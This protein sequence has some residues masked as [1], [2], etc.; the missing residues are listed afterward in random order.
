MNDARQLT[1]WCNSRKNKLLFRAGPFSVYQCTACDQVFV[2]GID[3]DRTLS[4]Y[5]GQDYFTERNAYLRNY[6][7]LAAH[8]QRVMYRI[9]G[10][11]PKG[12]LLDIGCGVGILMEVAD[13]NGYRATG[14]E[15][16]PWASAYARERGLDVKT[17]SLADAH[18]SRQ[19]F[20]IVILNHVLE[21]LIDPV[22]TLLESKRVL[23]DDGILVIGVPNFGSYVARRK[24]A[25]WASLHPDQHIWQFTPESLKRLLVHTGFLPVYF[26]AKDNHRIDWLSPALPVT[27]HQPVRYHHESR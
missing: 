10:F 21:H 12:R 19:E 25:A 11:K 6:R 20:D 24:K 17:G 22:E 15:L 9:H 23:A 27:A 3:R 13:R 26:E 14:V 1:C 2:D 18:F 8:F 16:S 4:S 5:S 7:T